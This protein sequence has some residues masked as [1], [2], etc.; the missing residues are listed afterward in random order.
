MENNE[1]LQKKYY[2]PVKLYPDKYSFN[3]QCVHLCVLWQQKPRQTSKK[4]G[5]AGLGCTE[6]SSPSCH[7]V[8]PP[9]PPVCVWARPDLGPVCHQ[10]MGLSQKDPLARQAGLLHTRLNL[11]SKVRIDAL[12]PWWFN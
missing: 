8:I 7:P 9:T 3:I 2:N 4:W 1:K 12:S 6:G 5:V 10:Q 11:N